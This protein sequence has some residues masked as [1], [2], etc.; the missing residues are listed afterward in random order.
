M[1]EGAAFLPGLREAVRVLRVDGHYGE[2][3]SPIRHLTARIAQI[4]ARIERDARRRKN[5]YFPP[6]AIDA[7]RVEAKRL[8]RTVSAIVEECVKLGMPQIRQLTPI[9]RRT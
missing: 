3:S 2:K 8:D 4:E 9:R 1:S 6:E 5:L 7:I